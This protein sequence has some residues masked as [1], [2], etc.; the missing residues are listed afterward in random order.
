MSADKRKQEPR[1]SQLL[2]QIWCGYE[3]RMMVNA[4]NGIPLNKTLKRLVDLGLVKLTRP[5]VWSP[6]GPHIRRTF[7]T[8]TPTGEAYVRL[9]SIPTNYPTEHYKREPRVEKKGRARDRRR[10]QAE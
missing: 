4:E 6:F 3:R 5:R 8:C 7:A 1:A 9:M 2:V 10:L